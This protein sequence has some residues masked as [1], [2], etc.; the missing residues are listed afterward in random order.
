MQPLDLHIEHRMRV[1]RQPERRLDVPRE[2]LLVALLHHGP[3]LLERGVVR[4]LEQ[5]L[6]LVQVLEE[7][8]LRDPERL[9]D[10]GAQAGVALGRS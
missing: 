10:E 1:H 3:L 2:A 4:E 9:F 5:A 8:G 7:L 6:E